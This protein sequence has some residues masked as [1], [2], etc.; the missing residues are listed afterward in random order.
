MKLQQALVSED[1]SGRL[2]SNL[3]VSGEPGSS[4]LLIQCDLPGEQFAALSSGAVRVSL[5]WH[6]PFYRDCYVQAGFACLPLS[7]FAFLIQRNRTAKSRLPSDPQTVSGIWSKAW[8]YSAK[9]EEVY[10]LGIKFGEEL[11]QHSPSR[12]V[13]E[14]VKEALQDNPLTSVALLKEGLTDSLNP[15]ELPFR[16]MYLPPTLIPHVDGILRQL[17]LNT[18]EC[19]VQ[20]NEQAV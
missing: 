16:M 17:S 14:Q 7:L 8:S 1:V 12:A 20:T 18:E 15:S 4:D 11:G 9:E 10:R 13:I 6:P 2:E 5:L 3:P 19:E